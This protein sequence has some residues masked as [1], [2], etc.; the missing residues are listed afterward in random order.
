MGYSSDVGLAWFSCGSCG[1]KISWNWWRLLLLHQ[2]KAQC[3]PRAIGSHATATS[4]I[5]STPEPNR[6]HTTKWPT[7]AACSTMVRCTPALML[8]ASAIMGFICQARSS[9][10]RMPAAVSK[11]KRNTCSSTTKTLQF[12]V[13]S[14]HLSPPSSGS[15][16]PPAHL[17]STFISS[18]MLCTCS[19]CWGLEV[20]LNPIQSLPIPMDRNLTEQGLRGILIC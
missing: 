5:P 12:Q 4:H 2:Q 19:I 9:P 10:S 3:W 7:F 6:P 20:P 13:L 15:H 17:T 1:I 16:P 11:K 8:C 14:L 18:T